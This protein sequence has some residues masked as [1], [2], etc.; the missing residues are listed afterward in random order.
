MPLFHLSHFHQ[1][2]PNASSHALIYSQS[3]WKHIIWL[4]LESVIYI[5]FGMQ[6]CTDKRPEGNPT[7]WN[8]L[9]ALPPANVCVSVCLSMYACWHA[10]LG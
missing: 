2:T 1:V 5:W 3:D 10:T 8:S 9:C 6:Y 4:S 7:F